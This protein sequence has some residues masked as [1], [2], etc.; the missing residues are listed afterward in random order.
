MS[1]HLTLKVISKK[2]IRALKFSLIPTL[3]KLFQRIKKRGVS[4]KSFYKLHK[5]NTKKT[6]N[7]QEKKVTGQ[8][9]SCIPKPRLINQNHNQEYTD[10]LNNKLCILTYIT[11]IQTRFS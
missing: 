4:P 9:P 8:L 6:K 10:K 1:L 3:H 2:R 7:M 11:D 5:L